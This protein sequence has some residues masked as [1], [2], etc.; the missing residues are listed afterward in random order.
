MPDAIVGHTGFVGGNLVR[1]THF[2]DCYNSAT[3][4]RIAGKSYGVLVCSGAP[5]EKW[6][7]NR[8]PAQDLR[9]IERLMGCLGRVTA[10]QVILISTVDVYPV[11][12]GVDENSIIDEDRCTAYARHRRLL[13][14]FLADRFSTLIV[15]LPG[16]F[17]PGLKKN[18]I[19]DFLHRKGLEVIHSESV[20]QFYDLDNLWADVQVAL[21]HGLNL[22]NFATEPVSARDVAREAFGI[23]FD[24]K[25]PVVAAGYDF[26]SC[27]APFFG[28]SGGYLYRRRQV[29]NALK[30][31]VQSQRVRSK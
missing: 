30:A 3:I 13:E 5:A 9:N 16:L 11:P 7:A 4:E 14:K 25:P 15:R 2:D 23:D 26:R 10:R 29:M 20:F 17:G 28:G 22:V 18:I 19:Y 1:Q 6:K 8:E 24:Q 21:G 12:R 31:F 27:H